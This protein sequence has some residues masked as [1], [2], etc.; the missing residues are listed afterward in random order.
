[1]VNIE[2]IDTGSPK[3]GPYS[4]GIKAGNFL[5]ISGQVPA[6]EAKDI[7]QQTLTAFEKIKK[8]LEAGGVGVSNIV[9][10][11]VFLKNMSDFR[12]MNEAYKDF[13]EQNGVTERFPARSTVE[14]TCPL[15]TALVEID[16]I[17]YNFN[18]ILCAIR[19]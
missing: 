5:F 9:K 10:V 19:M 3:A 15:P 12:E 2:V 18:F 17:K 14:A 6:P 16:A 11:S 4:L 13:F 7:R 1:M 8:I